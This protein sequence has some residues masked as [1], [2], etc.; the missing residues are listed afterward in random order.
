MHRFARTSTAAV[1]AILLAGL[2]F[3][4]AAC[5]PDT[6]ERP[7]DLDQPTPVPRSNSVNEGAAADMEHATATDPPP[8]LDLETALTVAAG[9][10]SCI[11]RPPPLPANRFG[12]LDIVTYTRRPGFEE[13]RVFYGCW[14][15]HSAVNSMWAI[16]RLAKEN[17]EIPIAGLI[18]EKLGASITERAMQG[19]LE[20]LA[21][22]PTFER[23]YG[24]VWLLL[25]HAELASWDAPEAEDWAEHVEPAADLVA[26]RLAEYL[27]E[28]DRPIRSGAHRN[29]A[30]SVAMGLQAVA[31]RPRRN[32][33]TVLRNT[34]YRFVRR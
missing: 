7:G 20:Y 29:T 32:L 22:N 24:W 15:W 21:A 25:L 18:K 12:Y 33:E 23:P 1:P 17:P 5:T 2:V 11:D 13:D 34:A 3:A 28:L 4:W 6:P 30:F 14:D 27:R 8:S 19:E 31:M 9:P 10:L 26:E 16:V